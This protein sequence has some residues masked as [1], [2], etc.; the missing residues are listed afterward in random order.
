MTIKV[1]R[2]NGS[3]SDDSSPRTVTRK[4]TK[5]TTATPTSTPTP[6]LQMFLEQYPVVKDRSSEEQAHLYMVYKF[7]LDGATSND[8]DKYKPVTFGWHPFGVVCCKDQW[9]STGCEL[10]SHTSCLIAPA[11]LAG[12]TSGCEFVVNT[13]CRSSPESRVGTMDWPWSDCVVQ[14]CA[15]NYGS[16]VPCCDQEGTGTVGPQYQCPQSKPNC[17]KYVYNETW[18]TCAAAFD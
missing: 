10:F 7:H 9:T 5:K 6:T 16:N 4:A 12:D 8:L 2:S 18:G 15:G 14:K 11:G 3:S 1:S 13:C 17:L